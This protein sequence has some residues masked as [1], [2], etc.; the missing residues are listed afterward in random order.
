LRLVLIAIP[1]GD[2]GQGADVP[3]HAIA[4]DVLIGLLVGFQ[5]V[6]RI[7]LVGE[8][9][10]RV[11]AWQSDAVGLLGLGTVLHLRKR[12]HRQLDSQRRKTDAQQFLVQLQHEFLSG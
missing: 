12:R 1:H 3:L 8:Q 2:P 11:V 7:L 6:F 5:L 4:V 10:A 9:N